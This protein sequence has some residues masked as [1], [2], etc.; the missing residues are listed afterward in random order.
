MERDGPSLPYLY[1]GENDYRDAPY[2]AARQIAT[3]VDQQPG[4]LRHGVEISFMLGGVVL[5][6]EK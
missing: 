4:G 3:L 1:Q 5:L 6:S 2:S